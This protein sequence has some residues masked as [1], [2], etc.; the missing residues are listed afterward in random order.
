MSSA[1]DSEE[2]LDRKFLEIGTARVCYRKVGEGPALVLLHGYPLSGLTWR[3]IILGLSR[4]FTCYAFDLGVVPLKADQGKSFRNYCRVGT[5]S[6]PMPYDHSD[7][8]QPPDR[9]SHRDR[10]KER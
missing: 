4:S 10:S 7:E 9:H 5:A 1:L 3:K 6:S 2:L 8:S